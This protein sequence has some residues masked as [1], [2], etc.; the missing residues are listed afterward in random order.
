MCTESSPSARQQHIL[1]SNIDADHPTSS[2]K[3]VLAPSN[4]FNSY[5]LY[6]FLHVRVP[7]TRYLRC[8]LSSNLFHFLMLFLIKYTIIEKVIA[9]MRIL[10]ANDRPLLS[11][12]WMCSKSRTI[13]RPY[14]RR[15]LNMGLRGKKNVAS[16]I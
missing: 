4:I 10:C 15:S 5:I 11:G 2:T 14:M 1:S 16:A 13:L 6:P 8:N 7:K 9:E 12:I 3:E